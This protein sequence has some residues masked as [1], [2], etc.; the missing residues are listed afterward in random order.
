MG[1]GK[2]LGVILSCVL[3]ISAP[4]WGQDAVYF[5]NLGLEN[6]MANRKIHYF[7]KALELNPSLAV[8][9]CRLRETRGALLFSGEIF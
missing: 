7:S 8:A 6:S 2:T 9:Y 5:Y 1:M 3:F 4:A